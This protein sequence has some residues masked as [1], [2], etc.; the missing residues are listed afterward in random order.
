VKKNEATHP[1]DVAFLCAYTV[2]TSAY[3]ITKL[4]EKFL[5]LFMPHIQVRC[6][7]CH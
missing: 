4:V 6:I 7:V 3:R 5:G 1:I 2:V